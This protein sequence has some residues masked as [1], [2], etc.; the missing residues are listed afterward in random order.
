ME[1]EY[2]TNGSRWPWW[3]LSRFIK[4]ILFFFFWLQW[5]LYSR[6]LWWGRTNFGTTTILYPCFSDYLAISIGDCPCHILAVLSYDYKA[7]TGNQPHIRKNVWLAVGLDGWWTTDWWIGN[8]GEKPEQAIPQSFNRP[9]WFTK[10]KQKTWSWYWTWKRT[11]TGPY[12][13]LFGGFTWAENTCHHYK[14]P[15]RGDA[16]RHRGLQRP[17]EIFDKITGNCEYPWNNGAGDID[18]LPAGNCGARFQKGLFGL[19]SDYQILFRWNRR[20]DCGKGL[21]NRSQCSTIC[22]YSWKQTA[23]GESIFKSDRERNQVFPAGS[24]YSYLYPRGTWTDKIFCWKYRRTYPG[25]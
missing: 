1:R 3:N 7:R 4:P 9:V 5:P 13:F 16:A 12:K 19:C 18:N 22:S 20:F 11:G 10:R 25:G 21:A 8:A 2:R 14:G 23:D 17:W 24:L 6:C 15:V